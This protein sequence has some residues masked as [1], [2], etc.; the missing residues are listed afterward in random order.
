LESTESP[1]IPVAPEPLIACRNIL[2][3]MVPKIS[4]SYR[5]G[6]FRFCR[7]CYN[8]MVEIGQVILHPERKGTGEMVMLWQGDPYNRH[9]KGPFN[10]P[11]Q[12]TRPPGAWED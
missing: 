8:K 2:C 12:N 3:T 10:A 9:L 7:P 1:K 6:E 4:D 11:L 5:V